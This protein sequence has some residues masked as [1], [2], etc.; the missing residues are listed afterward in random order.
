MKH[1]PPARHEQRGRWGPAVISSEVEKSLRS[2]W[3]ETDVCPE[4]RVRQRVV[5][6]LVAGTLMPRDRSPPSPC[7]EISRLRSGPL[8]K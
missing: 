6:T 5:A 3:T 7:D 4:R 8:L 2:R 1:A